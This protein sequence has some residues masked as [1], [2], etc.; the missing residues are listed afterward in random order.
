MKG[1][2]YKKISRII[3]RQKDSQK[4]KKAE[5]LFPDP[6]KGLTAQEVETRQNDRLTNVKSKKESK[7]YLRIVADNLFNFCNIVCIALVILLCS[8]G[9]WDYTLSTSIILVNIIIGIWQEVKAKKAVSRLTV[10]YKA[11]V[12]VIRDGKEDEIDS[13]QIVLDDVLVLGAGAQAPVD[14]VL[15]DGYMEVDESILTGESIPI[16]KKVGDAILAGSHIVAGEARCRADRVGKDCYI[17]KILRVASKFNKPESMIFNTL[18]FIIKCLSCVLVVLGVFIFLSE[19]LTMTGEWRDLIITV[20]SSILGMLPVGMFMLTSTALA[21]SVLKLSKTGALPQDIYSIEMLA[22]VDT[23]L[24]DKTG[25]LTDGQMKV[26][27]VRKLVDDEDIDCIVASI[28]HWTK[29]SKPTAKALTEYFENSP[30]AECDEV[31][32]F[33]SLRKCSAIRIADK[34]YFLGAPDYVACPDAD[35]EEYC[36]SNAAVGRRTIMLS[37]AQGSIDLPDKSV[38]RPLAL[39]ALEDRL[40]ENVKETLDWFNQNDV[41]IKIISGDNPETVSYIAQKAGVKNAERYVNCSVAAESLT[42][43]VEDTVVFGRVSPSQKQEIVTALQDKGKVVGMIG[44]GVNDIQALKQSNCSISFLGAHE[45]ARNISRIVLL[46]NDFASMPSIVR[47]GRRVINNMEKVSALYIM[48]TIFIMIMTFAFSIITL[49][50]NTPS[51]PFDTKKIMLVEMFVIGLPTYIYAFQP[52]DARISGR[53]MHNI[54]KA[55]LSATIGLCVAVFVTYAINGSIDFVG[56]EN[57]GNYR[58]S[59]LTVA[60]VVASFGAL[61]IISMPLN[62]LR[63]AVIAVMIAITFSA[64]CIDASYL[65]SLFFG[66]EILQVR[67][68]PYAIAGGLCG[69]AVHAALYAVIEI[70]DKKWGDKINAKIKSISNSIKIKRKRKNQD[71]H[72]S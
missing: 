52:N 53:F 31:R 72:Q 35:I 13:S 39:F 32:S 16:R 10:V 64:A 63:T 7:S 19:R 36:H 61:V 44:D 40:R 55:S 46:N 9:A 17:E 59:M 18:N 21:G 70:L 49:V 28:N 23:L 20:A 68:L 62:K 57:V 26:A 71:A 54:I 8:I 1:D 3:G 58:N 24:L 45:V 4:L 27:D 37:S 41:D 14:C 29:D 60:L 25:T 34:C 11:G 6:D 56:V 48:K 50:T 38:A 33:S 15:L 22:Q 30:I 47:E 66:L 5:R 12:K 67:H 42:D 43:N 2:L 69:I 65:D 51:Y